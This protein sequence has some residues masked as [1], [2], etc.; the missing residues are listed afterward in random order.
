MSMFRKTKESVNLIE[1]TNKSRYF[2]KKLIFML[3]TPI[4]GVLR[5][6]FGMF[7]TFTFGFLQFLTSSILCNFFR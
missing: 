5:K 4:V 2:D 1:N 3:S 7:L 6:K